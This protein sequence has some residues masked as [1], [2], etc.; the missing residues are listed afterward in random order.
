MKKYDL[1]IV[2]MGPSGVFCAYELIQMGKHKNI[3]LIEQ[4]R[5]IEKRACPIEKLG[6]CAKCKPFCNIT[7]GFSGAGAFSDGKVNSYHLAT[8][9]KDNLYLGGNDGPSFSNALSVDEIKNLF[10]YTDDIYLKFGGETELS[11]IKYGMEIEAYQKKAQ[12]ESKQKDKGG[13]K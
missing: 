4:G 6:K 5:S 8:G 10:K 1:I 11:G 2:G 3:L 7:C 9:I 12:K 13:K